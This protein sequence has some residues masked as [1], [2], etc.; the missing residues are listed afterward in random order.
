MQVC[1]IGHRKIEKTGELIST[2]KLAVLALIN[3]GATTFYFGS[4]SEFDS[5]S[6]EIVTELKK[7]YPSIK[8]VYVRSSYQFIDKSYEKHL[9]K[10]YE[11]T[12]FPPKVEKAGKYSYVERNY[13]MID[14]LT[15]CV[16][17]YNEKY[18]L[19]INGQSKHNTRLSTK[20]KSGTRIAYKYAEKK[21]KE[22]I[23]LYK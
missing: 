14:N 1:F 19:S 20:R 2:L 17:Y 8:R 11:E 15:Y 7:I 13:V 5:L 9:L 21:K 18:N 12:Y 23:N 4:K 16:F 10:M 3:K 6:W 22:I